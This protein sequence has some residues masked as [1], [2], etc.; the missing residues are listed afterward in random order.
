[1]HPAAHITD[2]LRLA[3]EGRT[4]TEVARLTGLPRSTVRD[5]L[6]GGIPRSANGPAEGVCSR[7]GGGAHR[8]SALP[9]EYTYALGLYLGDG[10]ISAHRRG[11]YRLRFFLDAKYPGII[12]ECEEAIRKLRPENKVSRQLRSGGY[13][14]S[15][16]SWHVEI[17]AYSRA[18]GHASFLSTAQD[19][20]MSV[21]SS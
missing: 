21:P 2:V 20:S 7:C 4:A 10:C 3:R 19:E 1:M 15:S 17:A 18:R 8:F 5:W 12:D 13:A 14:G 9:V 11:V 6:R 16:E